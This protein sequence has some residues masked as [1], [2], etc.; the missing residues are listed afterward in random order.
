MTAEEN[1]FEFFI[2]DFIEA[3]NE[4]DVK[5]VLFG[6]IAVNYYGRPRSTL[7]ADI[8]IEK[9]ENKFKTLEQRLKSNNF[10]VSNNA[11]LDS[12][13]ESTHCSIFWNKDILLRLDIKVPTRL[14]EEEAL[15]NRKKIKVFDREVFI[16][17]PEEII[18]AK[19]IYASDQDYD[20]AYSMILRLKDQLNHELLDR[21][22]KR[23]GV[24][25]KLK[26]LLEE[27]KKFSE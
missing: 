14:L 19:L 13:N 17:I 20:D 7:A 10:L 27:S 23:E 24:Q 21:L 1:N 15:L 11:I 18:I 3:F 16:Q 6:G 5:Y 26:E 12:V 9:D 4:S 8:I 22:S 25:E 2:K